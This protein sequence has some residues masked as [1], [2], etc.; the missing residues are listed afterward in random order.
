[1]GATSPRAGWKHIDRLFEAGSLVGMT[2]C[3]LLDRFVAGEA[4]E[5][6]FE[7]LVDRHGAMVRSVCRSLLRDR[8]EADDAFQATFL[9]L[10][11]RAGAIRRRDAVGSWLYG[12]AC[13][14]AARA[15][16]EAARRRVL[17]RYLADRHRQEPSEV[18]PPGQPMPELLEEVERLP[19]RYRAPIVLCYLEGRSHQQAAEALGCPVR[20]VAT[21]LQRGKAK[22]RTRL[23]RR[24]LAPAA[25]LA[26]IGVES[27]EAAKAIPAGSLPSA[28]SEA[29]ARASVQFAA[30][31]GAGLATTAMGLAQGVIRSLFWN[32]CKHAAGVAFSLAIGLALTVFALTAAGQKPGEPAT[33]VAGRILDDRGQ[34]IPGAEVWMP[35]TFDEK[36]EATPHATADAQGRYVL[37][38]PAAWSRLPR[39]ELRGI[40]WAHASGHQINAANAYAALTGK[41]RSVD[42]TL[43]PATD[44]SFVVFGPDGRVVA[45]AV[46]EPFHFK[47]PRAYD[48]VPPAMLPAVRAVTDASGRALLSSMPREGFFTVQVTTGSFGSQQLRLNDRATEP[49]RREVRLRPSGR[50]EGR[51]VADH[52]EWARGLRVYASTTDPSQLRAGMNFKAEGLAIVHTGPDG[53]FVIPA[54]A[55]GTLEIGTHVDAGLPV[56]PRFPLNL[57]VRS[58]Q[59]TRADILLEQAVRVAGL[60][61][62]KG[63][64]DPVAGASISIGYGAP[65]QSDTVVSDPK[66]AFTS[67]VLAGD[68]TM[69]VISLPGNFVQL[70]EPWAERHRVPDR[71]ESFDL[72]PIEVVPAITIKGRLVDPDNRPVANAMINGIAGNRRYGFGRT[73]QAGSF[74]LA[75]V[76]AGLELSYQVWPNQHEGPFNA[77]IVTAEPLL[78]RAEVGQR[79]SPRAT[80]AAAVSGT[81]VDADRRPVAGVEVNLMIETG[82]EQRRETLTTDANG[83][84][85][86]GHPVVKGA[87]YRAIVEPGHYAVVGS[88]AVT[89][90]GDNPVVL[91]AISVVRLRTLAGRVVDTEGRPVVGAR[92]LNWGN[93]APL[94]EAV[95]GPSGRFQLEGFP[96]ERAWLFV[97]APGYRFHRAT[98]DPGKSTAELIVRRDDQPP[99]RGIASLG[100]PIPRERAIELAATVLKPYAER[101]IKPGTNLEARSRAIEVAARIDPDG[102]WRKC[103][104]GEAPWDCNPV[105]IAIVRHLAA[106]RPGE[107]EAIIPTIKNDFWRQH[108]RIELVDALPAS[109]RDRKLA[110]LDEAVT[111]ALGNADG[112]LK[113]YHL[114]EAIRR[115]IDLG[116]GDEAR[117]RL[118]EALPTAKAADAGDARMTQTRALIGHLARLDLKAALA[119]IPAGG[120]ERTINDFRGLTAQSIAAQHPAEAERLLD[121]TAGRYPDAY[122]VKASYR[123]AA[124]DLPRARH[125]AERIKID[126]LRGFA[127]GRIAEVVG[128]TDRATARRLRAEA[129]RA[130]DQ[131]MEKGMGGVWG[132]RTA[133]VMAA[134]LLPG[135]EQTDPDHLAE[136]V[137]RILSLRWYPRNVM[138][139][140]M[141]RPDTMRAHAALAAILARYD[142]A[143]ARSIAQPIIERLKKPFSDIDNQFFDRYAVLGTLALADPEATAELVEVIPDLKEEGLGQSRDIVRVIVAGALA[144]P[145]SAFWT[146]IRRAVSDLEIVERED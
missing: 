38:V 66:G 47:T 72:P 85:R 93:P 139:L 103:Q 131:A 126:V 7:A 114:G 108:V 120:D 9:V 101:I 96:R 99:E 89:A 44:T 43:G 42:L 117:R 22:L 133:A 125:I 82:N 86:D 17:E 112:G 135:I 116:R 136:A 92:V 48:L 41:A 84:F 28:L 55:A 127:L 128:A 63:T 124:V 105:R 80:K 74:E 104:A 5:A 36:P 40:V 88:E 95:T 34:P 18:T 78:L 14:V 118:D 59:T 143:L 137:D 49:A 6:A 144:S 129:F 15:R 19:E 12:V 69:Q 24:G 35:I 97:D 141:T 58:G 20:T 145:P 45:G 53:S 109:A 56:R 37:P 25:G 65:R 1:M 123:M 132:A 111:E 79:L 83:V 68:V 13:R 31:R 130:F 142:H 2:D 81:V 21:R 39:H 100:P 33:E 77:E 52:P 51:I 115:L 61:R 4:A 146:T 90:D 57:D 29:T 50:I 46:V 76:P 16:A 54:I 23:V 119:L 122:A 102:A 30:H 75:Q 94:T 62:V 8:D 106:S 140:M 87:R 10:A 70:G 26:V 27:A 73:D 91:P 64:S 67:H 11:R 110:L 107:A 138:D 32:Q 134:A 121:A 3:Q 98:S 60:I 71:V 113:V